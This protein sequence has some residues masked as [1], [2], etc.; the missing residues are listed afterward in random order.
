[1]HMLS[2]SVP[3]DWMPLQ[4]FQQHVAAACAQ[5]WPNPSDTVTGIL[6]PALKIILDSTA[7][8]PIFDSTGGGK[9]TTLVGALFVA[10][11]INFATDLEKHD[12]VVQRCILDILLVVFFKHNVQP[13]ELSA[14]STLQALAAFAGQQNSSENRLLALQILRTA[15]SRMPKDRFSRVLPALFVRVADIMFKETTASADGVGDS[16]IIDACREM[17]HASI[18][19]FG[20]AGLFLQVL[21]TDGQQSGGNCAPEAIGRAMQVAARLSGSKNKNIWLDQVIVDL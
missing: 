3:C 12:F 11:V 16:A 7:R 5:P 20:K 17:L 10:I 15:Q 18:E 9:E 13:Y 14:L 1:M 21:R 4:L 2:A 6:L 19:E 8:T